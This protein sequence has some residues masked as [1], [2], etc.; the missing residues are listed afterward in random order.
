MA[1]ITARCRSAVRCSASMCTVKPGTHGRSHD[2]RGTR[3]P[4][5]QPQLLCATQDPLAVRIAG[6]GDGLV[7]AALNLEWRPETGHDGCRVVRHQEHVATQ[8]GDTPCALAS[9]RF[10]G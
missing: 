8:V 9:V 2:G 5:L 3:R 10:E 4:V 1:S 7:V 6:L